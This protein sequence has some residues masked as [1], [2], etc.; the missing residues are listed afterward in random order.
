M[1]NGVFRFHYS[2]FD[3]L[4][5]LYNYASRNFIQLFKRILNQLKIL[6]FPIVS[7][8][9]FLLSYL[10][11]ILFKCFKMGQKGKS[12]SLICLRYTF[13]IHFCLG[14]SYSQEQ[15]KSLY[16]YCPCFYFLYLEQQLEA[17][18]SSPGICSKQP[19]KII[20]KALYK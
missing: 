8:Q 9:V 18:D 7:K 17:G 2:I 3:I 16:P 5:Q 1:E 14:I 4:G 6:V 13:G 15:S 12:P 19:A 10:G 11:N 20:F